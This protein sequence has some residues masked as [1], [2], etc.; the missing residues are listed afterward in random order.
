M[1]ASQIQGCVMEQRVEKKRKIAE[2]VWVHNVVTVRTGTVAGQCAMP[3][4]PVWNVFAIQWAASGGFG[5]MQW[6]RVERCMTLIGNDLPVH[7]GCTEG[8]LYA[9]KL[10][11]TRWNLP[12]RDM[13][14]PVQMR[15]KWP[16]G[17]GPW[18]DWLTIVLQCYD[19]VGW[20]M[21]PVKPSPK[22]PIMCWVGH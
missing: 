20:V 7:S 3:R 12:D 5:V 9:S 16:G 6:R 18:R 11:R 17:I 1:H 15:Q 8:D 2:S 4:W 10:R 21:W 19:T 13:M 14:K 22:W